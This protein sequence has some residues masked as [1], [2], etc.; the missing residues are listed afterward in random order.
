MELTELKHVLEKTQVSA[1]FATVRP[2]GVTFTNA[3]SSAGVLLGQI[4]RSEPGGDWWRGGQ[5]W[6]TAR[7][8]GGRDFARTHHRLRAHA[9]ARVTW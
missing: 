7:L 3:L 4:E 1:T 9:V 6:Q 5:R 2:I 8:C